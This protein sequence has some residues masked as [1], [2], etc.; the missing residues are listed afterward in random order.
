MLDYGLPRCCM[1]EPAAVREKNG[2]TPSRCVS[3]DQ[4]I[5]M[6]NNI[7]DDND[8]NTN[9]DNNNANNDNNN[10]NNNDDKSQR[11]GKCS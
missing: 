4:I 9:N 8:N 2:T 3:D 10:N 1:E 7:N 6:I 11:K 5:T